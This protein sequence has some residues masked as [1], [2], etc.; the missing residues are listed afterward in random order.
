MQLSVASSITPKEDGAVVVVS[1]VRQPRDSIEALG[2]DVTKVLKEMK[3]G[4]DNTL[5]PPIFAEK[6]LSIT[7]IWNPKMWEEHTS[8]SRY[9]RHMS[10]IFSSRLIRR[11]FP[12]FAACVLWSLVSVNVL[13]R[14][15]LQSSTHFVPYS[16]LSIIS[17]FVGFCLTLRTNQ[18]L[19]RLSEG[20][21]LWGRAFIATRDT[22]QLIAAY[23]YPKDEELGLDAARHLAI[24]GWLLK[25]QLRNTDETALI[26]T[27]LPSPTHRTYL[28]SQRKPPVFIIARI[29]QIVAELDSRG[30]LPIPAHDQLERNLNELNYV[31][32]MCE[33]LS[34]S[35][36]PPLYTS[37]TTRLLVFYL[38]CM[39]LAL[40]GMAM[41]KT[42]TV[43]V[44]A[45][46]G[47]TMLGLDEISHVLEE[48]FRLMPLHYISRNVMLDV[49][50]AFVRRPPP[51]RGEGE[52]VVDEKLNGSGTAPCYW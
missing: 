27:M 46:V 1:E 37:H 19:D 44:S 5:R 14:R 11:I 25:A 42:V 13:T 20:R 9:I 29:R 40:H 35:P 17:T 41:K 4:P 24:F 15:W 39:P 32:G 31:Y 23:V 16:S 43:L 48:P 28:T 22:A 6:R 52:G 8:R 2:K 47:Y 50:D 38:L 51:L 12:Q 30:Q 36:V 7:Q 10:G 18:G 45:A 26:E 3:N 21:E 34:G 49:V 33:R